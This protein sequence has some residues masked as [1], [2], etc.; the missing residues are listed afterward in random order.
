MAKITLDNLAH[1]YLP[2]PVAEEDYA[3]K[4]LN[5]DWV[6]GEAYALLGSSGC[7]KWPRSIGVLLAY[8]TAFE[9]QFAPTHWIELRKNH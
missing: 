1:S 3:L 6:D 5:L 9:V 4:E 2:N 8:W 7:G